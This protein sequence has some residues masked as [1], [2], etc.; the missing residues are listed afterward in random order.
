MSINGTT[1]VAGLM[2]ATALVAGCNGGPGGFDFDFRDRAPGGLDTSDAA[3]AAIADRPAPDGSGLI[4]YPTYQVAVARRGDTVAT[5]AERVGI[6]AAELAEFNGLQV[7]SRLNRDAVLAMP[8]RVTPGQAPRPDITQI[9]GAAIDRASNGQAT[10]AVVVQT[11]QEPV[12]HQVARG[13]TAFSI[14]R[15]YGVSPSSL[16]EWNGL[17]S[18]FAIREGQFL[19]IP[20]VVGEGTEPGLSAPGGGSVTPVPPSASSALPE[21]VEEATLPESPDFDQFRTEASADPEPEAVPVA[22]STS[23]EGDAPGR[24]RRPVQG[25]VLRPFSAR[26][27]GVDFRAA[28]GTAVTAAAAGTVAAITRDTDQVPILVLRH[29]GGL[30]TVYANIKDIEVEKGDSIRAGQRLAS[31]GGGDPAFLHFEVRRG[32]DAVDP[33]PLLR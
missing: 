18:D 13:E 30:L 17:G 20:L 21:T 3:R 1:R 14:A 10:P 25:E 22:V 24:L 8:R 2:L 11:G 31:V 33:E 6:G 27:E 7:D 12:R 32:F 5:V 29:E 4:T 19:L 16:A 28:E 15:L 26:N 23:D 9:A